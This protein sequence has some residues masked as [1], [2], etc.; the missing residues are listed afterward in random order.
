MIFRSR[1]PLRIGLAG[2]GTD[3]SP[4]SEL[5][6]GAVINA[7]I[8]HFAC[9]NIETI[10]EKV[11]VIHS[12]D[13]KILL[14]APLNKKL[15][16]DGTLDLLKGMYNR[17][18]A[19]YGPLQ[20]G[21]RLSTTVDAPLGS[22]LGTSSTLMVALA[23]AFRQMLSFSMDNGQLAQ[24][25]YEVERIDLG[26]AGG[27]QDQ[28]AAV[29]GGF[30]FM[31]FLPGD[32]TIV[33]PIQMSSENIQQLENNLVLYYSSLNR[34]SSTII[35]EQQQNVIQ[36]NMV[37]I[38][39]MHALKTQSKMMLTAL[40]SGPLDDVGKILD[41]GFRHKK[42]MAK[43]ISNPLIDGIYQA[44]LSAGATGGKISGAGGGG[45]MIFYCPDGTRNTVCEALHNFGGYI[46]PFTFSL[47]GLTAWTE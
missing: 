39:A 31:E 28:Y 17:I 21:I 44:A 33:T 24:F 41:F 6:G 34:E 25:A 10:D 14:E 8:S 36:Q 7:A 46:K 1:A 4:Y 2:G 43:N 32:K 40:T 3:V 5:Y 16:V 27:K 23:G 29:F 15:P 22:G 12:D 30:N 42:K 37:S 19:D 38:E 11:F 18:L 47:P 26:F 20:S 45:F 13:G 35:G 9:A